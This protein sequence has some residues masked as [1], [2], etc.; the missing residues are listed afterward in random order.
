MAEVYRSNTERGAPGGGDR[1]AV[2]R[3]FLPTRQIHRRRI[4]TGA[5]NAVI[6]SIVDVLVVII[7]RELTFGIPAVGG[8]VSPRRALNPVTRIVILERR[9]RRRAAGR[10]SNLNQL[11]RTRATRA[12]RVVGGG[13]GR[14]TNTVLDH[15]RAV[16]DLV[17]LELGPIRFSATHIS[18]NNVV[19]GHRAITVSGS[20]RHFKAPQTVK[21]EALVILR[22]RSSG[23]L[24]LDARDVARRV[25]PIGQGERCAEVLPVTALDRL[26][27]LEEAEEFYEEFYP[28][29][30]LTPRAVAMVNAILASGPLERPEVPTPIVF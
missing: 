26:A 28:G 12:D 9:G 20:P 11:V 17:V 7:G 5:H 8:G 14:R 27:T 23:R 19:L 4:S 6:G 1:G 30:N 25:V 13:G 18:G 10:L 16:A 15:R 3:D 24:V 2:D 29:D 22:R 21:T